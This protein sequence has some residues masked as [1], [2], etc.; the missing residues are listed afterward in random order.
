MLDILAL[1]QI[2]FGFIGVIPFLFYWIKMKN[3]SQQPITIPPEPEVWPSLT[4]VLPVRNEEIVLKKKLENLE[5]Q[6]YPIDKI[7]LIVIDSNS[8][9]STLDI[10]EECDSSRKSK[11]T[12]ST[13]IMDKHLGKSA[14]IN[15]ILEENFESDAMVITDADALLAPN[16][17]KRVG[18]WLSEERIGAV[19]GSQQIIETENFIGDAYLLDGEKIITNCG[20]GKN[21]SS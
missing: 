4:I 2:S 13:I 10:L 3:L 8:S 16:S 11:F 21:I 17:L 1:I 7:E 6:E 9:D 20:F 19:C 18:R 12:L 14:A 5:A 15:R